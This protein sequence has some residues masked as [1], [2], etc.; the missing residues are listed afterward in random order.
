MVW[1]EVFGMWDK[2]FSDFE[3]CSYGWCRGREVVVGKVEVR[4]FTWFVDG[5]I[6]VRKEF[7]NFA[8]FWK[9]Y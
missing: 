6:R 3:F 5:W 1:E 8:S 4:Y 9:G 7:P 2:E